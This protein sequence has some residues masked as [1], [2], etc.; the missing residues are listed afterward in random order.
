MILAPYILEKL[1]MNA[2]NFGFFLAG[3][4]FGL[5]LVVLA[6]K[7]AVAVKKTAEPKLGAYKPVPP[8]SDKPLNNAKVRIKALSVAVKPSDY[9]SSAM[10]ILMEL[11]SKVSKEYTGGEKDVTFEKVDEE[12]NKRLSF[13]VDTDFTLEN[14]VLFV[15][16]TIDLV[17]DTLLKI[18]DKFSLALNPV[19]K[20]LELGSDFRKVTVKNAV[21]YLRKSSTKETK[22]IARAQ[23][24]QEKKRK[25][26]LGK[27][28]KESP[29]NKLFRRKKERQAELETIAEEEKIKVY[30]KILNNVVANV[31]MSILP[32]FTDNVRRLYGDGYTE[33]DH[34]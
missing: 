4:C 7:I 17:E 32:A 13:T 6:Y 14:A 29:I 20:G 9:L 31:I 26:G 34:D 27:E 12:G 2:Y 11:V 30:H 23:L 15:E 8:E 25:K 5:L 22:K 33:E 19:L 28:K 18:T 24:K 3:V 1:K 16:K 21:M 10:D